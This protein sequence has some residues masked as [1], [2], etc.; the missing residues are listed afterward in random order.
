MV[1]CQPHAYTNDY[2]ER[3]LLLLASHNIV[4]VCMVPT[5]YVLMVVGGEQLLLHNTTLLKKKC[6][7]D[8]HGVSV[9]PFTNDTPKCVSGC[10]G[11]L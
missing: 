4:S 9:H 11:N 8:T 5:P 2:R 6:H 1:V 10:H 3:G 7:S